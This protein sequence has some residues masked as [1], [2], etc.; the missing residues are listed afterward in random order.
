MRGGPAALADHAD[1]RPCDPFLEQR[2]EAEPGS[3]PAVE[4]AQAV[5][6]D[7]PHAGTVDDLPQTRLAGDAFVDGLIEAGAD[8]H[9][10][11]DPLG[12]AFIAGRSEEHTS[13]L[14]SLI[15]ISYAHI[16]SKK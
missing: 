15:R 16:Y 8:D 13:D 6:A 7:D 9:Q 14:Q 3:V 5:R 2:G 11:P 12:G 1:R 10:R 4:H